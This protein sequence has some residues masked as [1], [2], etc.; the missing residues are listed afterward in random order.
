MLFVGDAEVEQGAA[1]VRLR[2]G[3]NLDHYPWVR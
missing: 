3:A 1:A 2:E